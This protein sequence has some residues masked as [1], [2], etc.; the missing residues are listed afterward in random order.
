[1]VRAFF[2]LLLVCMPVSA[3]VRSTTDVVYARPD[4]KLLKLDIHHP[5][6]KNN[7][8]QQTSPA[9]VLIHGGGWEAG[10]RQSMNKIARYFAERRYVVFNISYRLVTKHAN[11]WPAQLDDAQTA[12]RWIRHHAETY[13]VDPKR[14]AAIGVS[15]GGHL[16]AMLGNVDT[17]THNTP[18]LKSYSSRVNAV[19]SL[20]GPS[21]LTHDFRAIKYTGG[22]TVQDVVNKL[23]GEPHGKDSGLARSASPIFNIDLKTPPHML[24]HGVKD[25]VVPVDQARRFHAALQKTGIDCQ[26]IEMKDAGHAI[27]NPVT[28]W[29]TLARVHRFLDA[30]LLAPED[31]P[32]VR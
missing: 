32:Q 28:V 8:N 5:P 6:G 20:A 23:L 19:V 27:K 12:V 15:A 14:I 31:V 21:D 30:Q 25:K 3:A 24:V 2:L 11:K 16:A 18:A 4:G 29:M 22:R 10:N 7:A 26:Y 9:V 1:M 17:R 13:R